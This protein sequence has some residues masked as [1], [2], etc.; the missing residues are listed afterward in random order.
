[1]GVFLLGDI[2]DYAKDAVYTMRKTGI[3]NGVGENAF[4]PKQ[5]ATR[6]MAARMVDA[7]MSEVG[8]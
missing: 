5:T 8:L 4:A 1:M 7:M 2:S 3:I 6:A